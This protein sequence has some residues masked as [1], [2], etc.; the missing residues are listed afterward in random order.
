MLYITILALIGCIWYN[1]IYKHLSL[2]KNK[3]F[4]VKI[5]SMGAIY[6]KNYSDAF[7]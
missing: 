5:L 4:P 7:K 1:K 6:E 2:K 3:V